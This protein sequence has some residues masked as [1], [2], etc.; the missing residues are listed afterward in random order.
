[1]GSAGTIKALLKVT[2]GKKK[3]LRLSTLEQFFEKI[4]TCPLSD[5]KKIL[6]TEGKRGDIIV[7]GTLLLIEILRFFNLSKISVTQ[8]GLR[9]GILIEQLKYGKI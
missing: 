8:R 2:H 3:V 4:K 7:A 5:L 6:K 9:D 1:M